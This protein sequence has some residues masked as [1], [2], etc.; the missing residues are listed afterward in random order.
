MEAQLAKVR[1]LD[2]FEKASSHIRRLTKSNS[3]TKNH[4]FKILV[5]FYKMKFN[6]S[7]ELSKFHKV[8]QQVVEEDGDYFCDVGNART[9]RLNTSYGIF[10]IGDNFK[11]MFHTE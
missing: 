10:W 2:L 8:I 11:R 9:V 1:T 5:K 3:H 6:T 7:T 4:C